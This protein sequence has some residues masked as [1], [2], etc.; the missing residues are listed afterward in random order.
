MFVVDDL[1][2]WLVGR[3]ADAGSKRLATLVLGSDQARAL[4]PAVT[5]AVQATVSELGPSDGEEA[6]LVAGQINRA[7]G[8]RDPVPL[9]P[10]RPTVLEALQ[11]G[12]AGQ[13]SARD[14]AGPPAV[15][16][17]GVP[18]SEVAAKLTGHLV[19]EIQVRGSRGGPLADLADQ[20]NHD[21]THLQG[22][23]LEGMLAQV[24]DW[25]GHGQA[26]A[27]GAAGPVGQPLAEVGD[28]FALEV[29]RPVEPDAPQRALPVLPV[30]VPREHDTALATVVA[31]AAA[32]ASGIAVLVGESSTGKTRACWQA[33]EVL[34]GLEPEWRLW[35]P[36][37]PH[38]AQAGLPGVGPRTVVWLNEAQRYLET[39]DGTGEQLAAGLR[40]LLPD[41]ARGPALV[42]ATLWPE[43]WA[44]LTASPSGATDPHA[45]ARELVAGH[46]IR[47]PDAFTHEELRE[48]A[49]ADDPR[50][51]QAAAGSRDG[52]VI[53]YLAGAPDLL[54]RY[55]NAP[56]AARALIDAAMDAHRLG[57][58]AALPRAFLEAAAPGY[59]TDTE[60]NELDDGWLELTL[61]YTAARC[62]GVRGPLAPIR[63]RPAPG[64]QASHGDGRTWQLADYL[65]QRGRHI[66]REEIPPASFWVAAARYADPADL[67]TLGEAASARGLLR[68]AACL[69]KHASAHGDAAAGASLVRLLHAL[70]PGDPRPADWAAA[71]ASLG[72]PVAVAELLST[73]KRVGATGQV[74]A[75][76]DRDPTLY[77]HPYDPRSV[78]SLLDVLRVEGATGQV[79]TLASR[80]AVEV[81]L[82]DPHAV[83]SL[84]D[85]LRDA[86]ATAQVTEVA[87]RAAVEVSLDDLGGV[88]NL[89]SA[90]GRA[91]AIGQIAA[92]ATRASPDDPSVVARVL[93]ELHKAGATDQVTA[94]ADRVAVARVSLD[95]PYAVAGLLGALQK[96]GATDQ[97]TALAD[98]A[99][100]DVSFDD[101]RAVAI[102]LGALQKVG[103]T[104]QVTAL[105]D[106]AV[107]DVSLDDPHGVATVLDALRDVGATDHVTALVNR[108]VADVSVNSPRGVARLLGAL[109]ATGDTDQVITLAS[110]AAA[111]AS[112]DDP[113][114]VASLLDALRATGDTGP[115]T[116]L[117]DRH[118]A[119]HVSLDDPEA[120]DR[121]MRSL[122]SARAIGQVITLASRAAAHA[123][124]D[125]ARSAAH[126]LGT[127]RAA[128]D[129]GPVTRLLADT[130]FR[131][132]AHA[133]LDDP[134]AVV[135]LMLMLRAIGDT[136]LVTTLLDRH[137]AAYVSFDNLRSV[138]TLLLV[139]QTVGARK[140][141]VE[142]IERLPAAGLFQLF[143]RYEGR[144]DQFRFGREPDGRPAGRW[145]WPD[146][147]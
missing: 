48:L 101:P 92:L 96:V 130:A 56:P 28:P 84:L 111:H 59:L 43:A 78:V 132:A 70:H 11:A 61:G 27:G 57:M 26:P 36:I 131:A 115:V 2:G 89:L 122:K 143:C 40:K 58:R 76:L 15:R 7:F 125:D 42:L 126:L 108:A 34:R 33:L 129:T 71:R 118:P 116:T 82:D 22:Q 62:K 86:G 90:L 66:R 113:A 32:G 49:T 144:E 24:L 127:L 117:L 4:K 137:P 12:I 147:G 110:R 109:R 6:D 25:L 100:V 1:V 72:D 83:T 19:R 54:A 81:S 53:Q 63:P 38:G 35:H 77:A 55:Q 75:L 98:R 135:G 88:A 99:A 94:L 69:Y 138:G 119:A 47:V 139:L 79:A 114:S 30:Y 134:E 31:A 142:L 68:D 112:L 145:A 124:L 64:V 120:V 65:D 91:G 93:D 133:R 51:A 14:N 141:A 128:G 29:H 23:R 17:P 50:L 97:V 74:A 9:P 104:A 146:L 37:D 13:L 18:V 45:H 102:L 140:Q 16:L 5:S 8:R 39:S 46:T 85:A 80:A 87:T 136:G 67:T 41:Q 107:A 52:Q 3:V 103:A 106:R 73:L 20:L 123:S 60:W 44:R 95:S 121:L 21:L 10:G 105:A